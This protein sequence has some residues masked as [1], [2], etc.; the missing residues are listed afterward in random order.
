MCMFMIEG[1]HKSEPLRLPP[2]APYKPTPEQ[3]FWRKVRMDRQRSME[4]VPRARSDTAYDKLYACPGW[5][6]FS[7]CC[8]ISLA[9]ESED[10]AFF[11]DKRPIY[12]YYI[13]IKA[14]YL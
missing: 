11:I 9:R 10:T 4:K 7:H 3:L 12:L 13:N 1:G 5:R 6:Y 2:L 14:E 8:L